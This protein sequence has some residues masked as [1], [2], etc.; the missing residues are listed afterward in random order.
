MLTP[1]QKRVADVWYRH[2]REWREVQAPRPP[3]L[4]TGGG[5]VRVIAGQYGPPSYVQM[6]VGWVSAEAVHAAVLAQPW[7]ASELL[8]IVRQAPKRRVAGETL[9]SRL[10][11]RDGRW[12]GPESRMAGLAMACLQLAEAFGGGV[13]GTA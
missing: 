2:L 6:P 13:H 12:T 10:L 3:R 4:K 9:P 11:R 8:Q 1:E 5:H 7:P